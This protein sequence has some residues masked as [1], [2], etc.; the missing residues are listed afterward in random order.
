MTFHPVRQGEWTHDTKHKHNI[1]II[2]LNIY[3][4]EEL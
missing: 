1:L 4:G 2:F 3:F